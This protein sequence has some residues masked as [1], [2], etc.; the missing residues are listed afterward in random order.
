MPKELIDLENEASEKAS[1]KDID[2]QAYDILRKWL[3]DFEI[4]KY[5]TNDKT[6]NYIN[7]FVVIFM[8]FLIIYIAK[9]TF[10]LL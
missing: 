1:D 4:P 3:K 8:S 6:W 10:Y 7:F 5:A 2:L 9:E